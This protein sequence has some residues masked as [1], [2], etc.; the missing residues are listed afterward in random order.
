MVLIGFGYYFHNRYLFFIAPFILLIM[1]FLSYR[2][3]LAYILKTQEWKSFYAVVKS[4]WLIRSEIVVFA[5]MISTF[6]LGIALRDDFYYRV[7]SSIIAF[8][9]YIELALR[10]S[11]LWSSQAF[12]FC[13]WWTVLKTMFKYSIISIGLVVIFGTLFFI[14]FYASKTSPNSTIHNSFSDIWSALFKTTLMANGEYDESNL[15][16]EGSFEKCLMVSFVVNALGVTIS[17]SALSIEDVKDLKRNTK[18]LT[19]RFES[20]KLLRY[21]GY[22]K[23]EKNGCILKLISKIA[24]ETNQLSN[25]LFYLDENLNRITSECNDISFKFSKGKIENIKEILEKKRKEESA[26]EVLKFQNNMLESFKNLNF[27]ILKISNCVET[28]NSRMDSLQ[29]L[30]EGMPIYEVKV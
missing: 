27:Q 9:I 20:V 11:Q 23:A 1:Q 4:F 24:P 14:T 17:L 12:N 16:L 10:I 22:I 30:I 3:F 28:L 21:A 29:E 7:L 2:F 15:N 5:L 13:I 18:F 25:K 19:K 8:L 26:N 6:L